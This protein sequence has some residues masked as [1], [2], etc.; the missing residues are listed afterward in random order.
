MATAAPVQNAQEAGQEYSTTRP[1]VYPAY[2]LAT[3]KTFIT[4]FLTPSAVKRLEWLFK[5][6]NDD[7]IALLSSYHEMAKKNK[8]LDVPIFTGPPSNLLDSPKSNMSHGFGYS[9]HP[10][11][12]FFPSMQHPGMPPEF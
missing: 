3:S 2:D 12:G 8:E 6:P 7:Q 9:E 5:N 4:N 11:Q 10:A 1:T